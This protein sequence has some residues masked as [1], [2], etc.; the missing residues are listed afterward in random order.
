MMG[1]VQRSK[2][3]RKEMEGRAR[4]KVSAHPRHDLARAFIAF[5]QAL[6]QCSGQV[7]HQ[8]AA[9]EREDTRA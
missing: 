9:I 2:R 5:G 6:A 3:L 8:L 1:Q 7:L 4:V